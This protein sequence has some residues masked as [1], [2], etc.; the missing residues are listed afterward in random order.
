MQERTPIP[1]LDAVQRRAVTRREK[2][3]LG[4]DRE[5][6]AGEACPV[7]RGPVLWSNTRIAIVVAVGTVDVDTTTINHTHQPGAGVTVDA[8]EPCAMMGIRRNVGH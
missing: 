4:V 7:R 3:L 2:G 1:Q 8:C 6:H 5:G